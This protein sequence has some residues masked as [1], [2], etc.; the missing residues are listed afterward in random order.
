MQGAK[1]AHQREETAAIAAIVKSGENTDARAHISALK[2]YV[3][4]ADNRSWLHRYI[5]M[6]PK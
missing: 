6:Q 4:R 1:A 2:G 3:N 5:D